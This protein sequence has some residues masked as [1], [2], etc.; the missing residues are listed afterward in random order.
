MWRCAPSTVIREEARPSPCTV[1]PCEQ[2]SSDPT[3]TG[4]S[5]SKID[6]GRLFDVH[7]YRAPAELS[8]PCNHGLNS[9]VDVAKVVL[10]FVHGC[11]T[12]HRAVRCSGYASTSRTSI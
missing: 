8:G 2:R 3:S 1:S 10:T 12:S 11:R 6:T 4:S 7:P 5:D 9:L